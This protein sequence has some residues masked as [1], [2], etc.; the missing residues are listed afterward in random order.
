[1]NNISY[2]YHSIMGILLLCQYSYVYDDICRG[3]MNIF[4]WNANEN[5]MFVAGHLLPWWYLATRGRPSGAMPWRWLAFAAW[6]LYSTH[7]Q[8]NK[9]SKNPL[10]MRVGYDWYTY[11][12][13]HITIYISLIY[14]CVCV[15]KHK[16]YQTLDSMLELVGRFFA[17][18]YVSRCTRGMSENILG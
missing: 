7:P 18:I 1:M 15:R 14:I 17:R 9:K 16:N 3:I 4:L 6:W 5:N 12:Y 2:V 11:I 10:S 8:N 13:M